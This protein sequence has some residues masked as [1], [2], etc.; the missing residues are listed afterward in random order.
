MSYQVSTVEVSEIVNQGTRTGTK[1][2]GV[3]ILE[4]PYDWSRSPLSR[5]WSLYNITKGTLSSVCVGEPKELEECGDLT[6]TFFPQYGD[7]PH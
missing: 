3:E 1:G 5:G 4:D 7:R 6:V 2:W